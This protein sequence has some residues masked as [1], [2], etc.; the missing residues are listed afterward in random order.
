MASLV[1]EGCAVMCEILGHY[2][3]SQ[4][5]YHTNQVVIQKRRRRRRWW[6][7]WILNRNVSGAKHFIENELQYRYSED[8]KNL[9]RMSEDDFYFLLERVSAT[10]QKNDTNMREAIPAKEK[11]MITLRYLA[12]GN[13]FKTL[14]FFF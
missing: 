12:T 13:S 3:L 6:V 9:P 5:T 1:A 7:E 10:I 8:F 11:L 4:F 14:E 2:I